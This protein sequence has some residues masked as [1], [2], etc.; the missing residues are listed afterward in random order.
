MA[1]Y[2]VGQD[3]SIPILV[4][5]LSPTKPFVESANA[6]QREKTP[7]ERKAIGTIYLG[8]MRGDIEEDSDK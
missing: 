1:I 2:E 6:W 5:Y 7:P 3:I 8:I 4:T